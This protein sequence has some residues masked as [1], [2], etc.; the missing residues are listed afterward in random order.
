M[1]V[2]EHAGQERPFVRRNKL[3]H[4]ELIIDA[5]AREWQTSLNERDRKCPATSLWEELELSRGMPGQG[6]NSVHIRQFNER[7]ILAALRRLGEAS[8][9]DLARYAQLTNN[10]AGQIVRELEQQSLI[11][12]LGKRAGS[13]GQ[14]ATLLTLNSDGAYAIG[15]TIGRRSLR[16]L[17]VDF[18]GE[19]LARR[20]KEQVWPLPQDAIAFIHE[21]IEAFRAKLPPPT[22]RRIAGLGVAMPYNMGSWQ[23]ELG[24]PA[25]A[26]AAWS[27]FD[28]VAAVERQVDLPVFAENDGTAAAAAELFRGHGRTIDSFLYLFIGAAIGGGIVTGGDF[29]RGMHGNAG[30]VGLMPVAPSTLASAVPSNARFDVLLSRASVTA[31]LRHLDHSGFGIRTERDLAACLDNAAPAIAEWTEDCADALV[32]PILSA[33]RLLDIDTVV[34]DSDLPPALVR[35]LIRLTNDHLRRASPESR[36]APTLMHGSIGPEAAAIGAAILPLHLNFSP[37][38]DVLMGH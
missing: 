16:S 33:V 7:V 31:L 29:Q 27:D 26:V 32:V 6:S 4:H 2:R 22:R 19:V 12:T 9:A 10:A 24:M 15:V 8:K 28:L 11:K 30:D 20:S 36:E 38:R 21:S 1:A 17:L 18:H 3:I 34:I 13:R 14:P 35:D 37:N 25:Q 23:K 5:K